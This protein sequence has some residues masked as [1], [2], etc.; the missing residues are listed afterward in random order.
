MNRSIIFVPLAQ[1]T[2]KY[3]LTAALGLGLGG[4][5]TLSACS[6]LSA[7]HS[8]APANAL[9]TTW[10]APLPQ[11]AGSTPLLNWWQQ[12][13]DPLLTQLIDAAQAA[14]PTLASAKSHIE[15]ARSLRVSAGA[16]L[17]PTLTASASASR[18]KQDLITPL[19]NIGSAGVQTAWEIDLF[20]AASAGGN[21]AQARFEGA[22]ASWYAAQISVAAEVAN[23]YVALRACE[24]QT[25]QKQI[26]AN[27]RTQT[28]TLTEQSAKAGFQSPANAALS[29]ASAAQSRS[30]LIVQRTQCDLNIK[31]LVAMSA[32]PEPALRAALAPGNAHL[33]QPAQI[34]VA[35][36]PAQA[37]AQRPDLYN[38][39][40]EVI[41]ASSEV[42]QAKA[43]RLPRISLFGN[44]GR[45]RIESNSQ[46]NTG[47]VWSIGPVSV[48]LPLFDG[49]VR[50]ANV[51]AARARYDE[52]GAVY[53]SKLRNAVREVEEALVSLHS[54][55]ERRSDAQI[56]VDG[57]STSYQA[58]KARY[59]N[60]LA[61]LFE[62]EDARRSAVLAQSALIELQR[63]H[64]ATWIALYLALGGGW[65][66]DALIASPHHS[67]S[68]ILDKT[69]AQ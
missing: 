59:D 16:A 62:L 22:Q 45:T 56:A 8:P 1:R 2:L 67:M 3:S 18:G 4:A 19:A 46:V 41:A 24:A 69:K 27:S 61:N 29:L 38:A 68:A 10:Q 31:A 23:N 30:A 34:A 50:R 49:G 32:M 5:L 51:D 55:A 54:F 21:A 35:S 47:T 42:W 7:T 57:F 44:I 20:G 25:K 40:T 65:G 6:S 11:E 37:L 33:P 13:N 17:F 43:Q 63:E 48:V 14:S 52:A 60:G 12:F 39:A 9:P 26:D 36:V 66:N 53:Q 15:Q 58:T 28:A 64:I